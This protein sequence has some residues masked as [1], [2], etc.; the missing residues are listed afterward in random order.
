M[1]LFSPLI[2]AEETLAACVIF[3][4]DAL[5]IYYQLQTLN[6]VL[7]CFEFVLINPPPLATTF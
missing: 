2:T 5:I 6:G 3:S 4:S 1:N 7:P